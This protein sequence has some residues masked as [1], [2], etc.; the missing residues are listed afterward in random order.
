MVKGQTDC[1]TSRGVIGMRR[2][3]ALALIPGTALI[4]AACGGSADAPA[5][6]GPNPTLTTTTEAATDTGTAEPGTATATSDDAAG[7]GEGAL[8]GTPADVGGPYGEL[9]DGVWAIGPAGEVEFRVTATDSLELV[10]VRANDGWTITGQEVES[11][12]IDVDFRSGPVTFDFEVEI[13][14]GVLELEI[15]QDIKPAQSGTFAVGEAA[16][17]AVSGDGDRLVLGD[18][19]LADGWSETSRE[20]DDDDLELDFRRDG[21]GF[22]ELWEIHADLD[23]GQLEIQV[24]YEIEG[25]FVQ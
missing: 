7:T 24:D 16:T 20:V 9:R 14:D 8:L 19:N 21:D 25:R 1:P 4:L 3:T 5:D 23:D 18:V 22:F 12:K 2:L 6:T 11:D 15:D 13:D 17:V 10:D